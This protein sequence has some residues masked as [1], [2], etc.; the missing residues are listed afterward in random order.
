M[1]DSNFFVEAWQKA[2]TNSSLGTGYRN[3]RAWEDFWNFFSQK[4]ARR[5]E[6]SAATVEAIVDWLAGEGV[7]TEDMEVLDVGC[8]P[9]TY[10][11]P[12][13]TRASHVVGLDSAP[14]MLKVL[15]ELARNCGLGDKVR[16]I[17]ARWEDVNLSRDFDLVFAA[18]TPAVNSFETLMKIISMSRRYCCLVSFA[19]GS[20]LILRDSLWEVV[21]GEPLR[22][23]AFDIIYP[24]NILYHDGYRPNLKFFRY[25]SCH[26]EPVDY[27]IEHYTRYFRIF[28]KE[29]SETI[30]RI[31]SFLKGRAEGDSCRDGMETT[32]GVMWWQ[33]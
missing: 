19:G 2:R 30:D 4:Y 20:K 32:V 8:G 18:N 22:S 27:L 3:E 13:A 24:F 29:D 26:D 11:L 15:E 9:G 16:T 1:I 23:A 28:G 12:L 21:M 6:V 14:R 5:N 31:T 7:L 33:Q 25:S 10:T 17:T